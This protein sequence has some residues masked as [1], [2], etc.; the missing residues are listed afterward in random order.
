MDAYTN[1]IRTIQPMLTVYMP[2]ANIDRTGGWGRANSIFTCIRVEHY[3]PGSR[4]IP[5]LPAGTP[6]I[7]GS[8]LSGGAI[9]GIVVGAVVFCA[10]VALGTFFWLRRK[11]RIARPRTTA[12][13][14]EAV[15]DPDAKRPEM[16]GSQVLE[17]NET[18]RKGEIDGYELVELGHN[19]EASELSGHDNRAESK[20]SDTCAELG[21]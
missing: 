6:Y 18:D 5:A 8:R 7:Y 2:V 11:R 12:D 4:V 3:Y 20:G 1:A 21:T 10:L 15:D 16:D 14:R 17:L 13:K 19:E 9:A